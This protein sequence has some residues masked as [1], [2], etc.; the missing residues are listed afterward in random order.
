MKTGCKIAGQ[1]QMA[2]RR[3]SSTRPGAR[4]RHK[5]R[6]TLHDAQEKNCS[7]RRDVQKF[8]RFLCRDAEK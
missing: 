7:T 8:W 2:S 4:R 6:T 5:R 1:A 3:P